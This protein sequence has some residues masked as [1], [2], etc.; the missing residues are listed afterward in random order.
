MK[1]SGRNLLLRL[2]AAWMTFSIGVVI[3]LAW[4]FQTDLTGD[5]NQ[6][7]APFAPLQEDELHRL[8]E[9]ARVAKS[10]RLISRLRCMKRDG[11]IDAVI[12]DFEEI[13]MCVNPDGSRYLHDG[14]AFEE[15]VQRHGRWSLNNT[16]L[17]RTT[18]TPEKAEEYICTHS[19]YCF[20]PSHANEFTPY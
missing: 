13:L 14:Q 19:P 18:N 9:S 11:S 3:H 7:V 15:F 6:L 5:A 2:V 20:V 16:E 10:R 8:Y 1:K 12:I 17:L 4:P